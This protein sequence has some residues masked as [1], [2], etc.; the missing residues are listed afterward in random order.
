MRTDYNFDMT[1]STKPTRQS[2]GN[3]QGAALSA[4]G[5]TLKNLGAQVKA[6][7]LPHAS[8]LFSDLKLEIESVNRVLETVSVEVRR[9]LDR[10]G[11]LSI[12]DS[13]S[14]QAKNL[15]SQT[16]KLLITE[17]VSPKAAQ[18]LRSI[19]VN[20]ADAAGNLSLILPKAGISV[21]RMLVP[22][23]PFKEPGRP[24]K[25]LRGEPSALVVRGLLDLGCPI[26]ASDLIAATGVSRASAYRTLDYLESQGFI[27]RSAPGVVESVEVADLI[28]EV[29][30][31]LS[32][33]ELG[34]TYQFI[35]PKGLEAI[36][37]KLPNAQV[38]Y[39]VTGSAAANMVTVVAS[40]SFLSIYSLDPDQLAIDLGLRP[41]P[42][43][44]D[45][46][47]NIPEWDVVLQRSQ[48]LGGVYCVS[49]A[50]IAIDLVNGPGR[51]PQ[52]G[53]AIIEQLVNG[54]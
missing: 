52:Q 40:T 3:V 6:S 42:S 26:S 20:F 54:K 23:N 22:N 36:L 18:E 5:E 25:S 10:Y 27:S 39:A 32:F 34:S 4:L 37:E 51:N 44:G 31:W 17:F 45:V 2:A 46:F 14:Q 53:E 13:L 50:Q 33:G 16:T 28:R 9:S 48:N 47:I 30:P 43:G 11:L 15:E 19:G 1:D 21:E 12:K 24:L 41:V 35:A 49:T 7:S 8:T 38:P 29:S